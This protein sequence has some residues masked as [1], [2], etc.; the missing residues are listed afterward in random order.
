MNFSL[1]ITVMYR[2]EVK[3]KR[4]NKEI[5]MRKVKGKEKY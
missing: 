5:N 3:R 2:K 4:G 1:M